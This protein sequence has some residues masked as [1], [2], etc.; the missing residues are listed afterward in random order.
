MFDPSE[1]GGFGGFPF[2]GMMGGMMQGMSGRQRRRRGEDIAH[3]LK[4]TLEDLY[5]GKTAKLKLKKKV[6]CSA[7][8]G[9]G[10]KSGAVHS[11]RSCNGQG[12][13]IS[14][15]P[16]GPGMVQQVQRVCPDCSGE[17]EVI[18][19][20]NRCKICLGKKVVEETKVLEVGVEKGM[21]DNQ[22]LQFRGE[23]D[24]EP[25]I[26]PG[27]VIIVLQQQPHDTFKRKGDDL[28]VTLDI[29][30]TEAL[31][32]FKI[33]VK[34]LNGREKLITNPPGSVITPGSTRCLIN[35]GMPSARGQGR[36]NMIVS[37]KINFPSS[38]EP[39]HLSKLE[40]LLPKRN[41]E[42]LNEGDDVESMILHDYIDSGGADDEDEEDERSGH[43]HGGPGGVQCAS[44]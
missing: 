33:P 5:N 20:K 8:K 12:M 24:Q 4:V 13:K 11:C 32:G 3:P 23:G 7:C 36:G 1:D 29:S 6:V 22:K 28:Y 38:I 30:L 34:Q 31:C 2:G 26:E 44:Q 37:F 17:G 39:E 16:I 35:E 42:P 27:D 25:G 41:A 19:A 18:D 10:G 40:G 21:R 14:I 9:L 15:Q 43:A